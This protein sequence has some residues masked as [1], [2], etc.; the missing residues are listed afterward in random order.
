MPRI[1]K[2]KSLPGSDH[3]G[4][5]VAASVG[6]GM[7]QTWQQPLLLRVTGSGGSAG[8]ADERD[9]PLLIL[10]DGTQISFAEHH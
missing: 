2:A 8:T 10:A 7:Q 4:E 1:Q 3:L 6:S 5:L 9:L